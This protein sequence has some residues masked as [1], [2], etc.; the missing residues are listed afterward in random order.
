MRGDE[1]A[2]LGRCELGG[3]HANINSSPTRR[4]RAF[5]EKKVRY[6]FT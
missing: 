5:K 3:I 2:R 4:E 1:E 6:I